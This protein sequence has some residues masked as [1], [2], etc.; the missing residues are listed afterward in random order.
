MGEI[1]SKKD[2]IALL[3]F[4]RAVIA[5][6]LGRAGEP[7]EKE[8]AHIPS[9]LL[10]QKRGIFVTLHKKG[11]LRGCIG[12]IEP[13]K[14]IRDGIQE[15]AEYAAFRDTRFSPLGSEELDDIDIEISVLTKPDKIDHTDDQDLISRIT[16]H[17]DG[18]IL[19]KGFRKAT[20]LPQ[21]WDQLSDPEAFLRHLCLKAGMRADEWKKGK[22]DVAV[23]QVDSFEE[24]GRDS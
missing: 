12:N 9:A 2:E 19:Q 22:L 20:F 6:K 17:V 7:P 11:E 4:A 3:R 13:T 8:I 24:S 15:N 5:A 14:T 1:F 23:Y 10:E 16:P 21:V 18:V